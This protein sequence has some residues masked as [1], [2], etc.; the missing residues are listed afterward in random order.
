MKINVD[1][2]KIHGFNIGII[3]GKREQ[4]ITY[5]NGTAILQE[6]QPYLTLSLGKYNLNISLEYNNRKES[7]KHGNK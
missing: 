3:T 5:E 6:Q 1:L 2:K 4:V 7:V